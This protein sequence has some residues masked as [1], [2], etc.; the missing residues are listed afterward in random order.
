MRSAGKVP[1][2]LVRHATSGLPIRSL[3][4]AVVLTVGAVAATSHAQPVDLPWVRVPAGQLR[5]GCVPADTECLDS[6][7][8]QHEVTLSRPFGLMATEVTRRHY[9]RFLGATGH[10][11]PPLPDYE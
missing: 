4:V 10:P 6:E 8:P 9:A 5:M 7:R 11:P 1:R 3:T 2:C